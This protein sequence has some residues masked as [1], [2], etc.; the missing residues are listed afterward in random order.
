MLRWYILTK[1]ASHPWGGVIDMVQQLFQDNGAN[2]VKAG[3]TK[4][5]S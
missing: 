4:Q 3:A 2:K 5:K 1:I